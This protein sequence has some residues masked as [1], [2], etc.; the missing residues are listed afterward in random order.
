MK[1]ALGLLPL[2]ASAAVGVLA[3]A[4]GLVTIDIADISAPPTAENNNF[5]SLSL[6]PTVEGYATAVSSGPV[7]VE[8]GVPTE[9]V[10]S[11]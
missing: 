7:A 11:G 3:T 9:T 1:F 8:S 10:F 2:L 5:G 6:P 4:S